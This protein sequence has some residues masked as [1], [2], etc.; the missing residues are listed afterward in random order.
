VMC[1]CRSLC[2]GATLL[3]RLRQRWWAGICASKGL[4]RDK[5]LGCFARCVGVMF[6]DRCLRE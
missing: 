3:L 2:P 5:G 1:V 6:S 4:V